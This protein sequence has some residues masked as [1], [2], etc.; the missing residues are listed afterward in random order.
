VNRNEFESLVDRV[1]D[2]AAD[3]R[4]R[5]RLERVATSNPELGELW[6]DSRAARVALASARSEEPP[7]GLRA[8][9]MRA[10]AAEARAQHARASRW[11][12][13]K[14]AFSARPAL[15]L[16]MAAVVMVAIGFGVA[17]LRGGLDAGRSLAP[18]T[19]ATLPANPEAAAPVTLEVDGARLEAREGREGG[20]WMVTL[21]THGA[22]GAVVDVEWGN[23]GLRSIRSVPAGAAAMDTERSRARVV[24]DREGAAYTMVFLTGNGPSSVF[25]SLRK[26]SRVQQ[27]VLRV[28]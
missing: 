22:V 19:V 25:V 15:A 6:Q 5:E 2:G 27:G 16:G 20:Q 17:V 24:V 8:D 18:S 28:P 4:D 26:G 10:I 14:A 3:P 9:V 11:S 12:A 13:L 21:A 7:H 23:L 1:L